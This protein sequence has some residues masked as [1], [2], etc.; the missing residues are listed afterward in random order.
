MNLAALADR[1][2]TTEA[3]ITA[4]LAFLGVHK[5]ARVGEAELDQLD[6]IAAHL[7]TGKPLSSFTYTP[8]STVEIVPAIDGSGGALTKRPS[9]ETL[10]EMDLGQIERVYVFL[11]RAAENEWHLPTSVIRQLTGSTPRGV[12]WKRFGFEF[13]PATRHGSERAWAVRKAA[14][15]FVSG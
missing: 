2:G 5:A 1:Y 6:A 8:T 10:V 4:R 14:W 7:A 11:E 13:V 3:S 15:D 12:S 9:D